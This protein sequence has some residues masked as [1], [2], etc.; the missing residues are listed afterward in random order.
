MIDIVNQY[1]G[2]E[3]YR[4]EQSLKANAIIES[5][6]KSLEGFRE[7]TNSFE[8]AN[9]RILG[10]LNAI[11]MGQGTVTLNAAQQQ[12]T[13]SDT[14]ARGNLLRQTLAALGGPASGADLSVDQIKTSLE[15]TGLI[16]DTAALK[17]VNSLAS[18]EKAMI[19]ETKK[20]DELINETEKLEAVNQTLTDVQKAQM[21]AEAQ[22]RYFI[23]GL[24][25]AEGET[26]PIRRGAILKDLMMPFTAW[27]KALA[28]GTLNM[29]EFASLVENF[30]SR[31]KPLL[32]SQGVSEEDIDGVR[33]GFFKKF[34]TVFPQ[35]FSDAVSMSFVSVRGPLEAA[36]GQ[37]AS[38]M[39]IAGKK[40]ED[41]DFSDLPG[42]LGPAFE[43]MGLDITATVGSIMDK[44][45]EAAAEK[46]RVLLKDAGEI[47]DSIDQVIEANLSFL[48]TG[49]VED[50]FD[51]AATAAENAA[52]LLT[53]F[54]MALVVHDFDGELRHLFRAFETAREQFEN[55]V[56]K[57][58]KVA[59]EE[60][61]GPIVYREDT[62]TKK[63]STPYKK[64]GDLKAALG[65][66]AAKGNRE[67]IVALAEKLGVATFEQGDPIYA[68]G[69]LGYSHQ[70]GGKAPIG[71]KEGPERSATDIYNDIFG[72][73]E[74]ISDYF[75]GWFDRQAG[76]A[77]EILAAAKKSKH[78]GNKNNENNN[79]QRA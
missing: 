72:E 5:T 41:I 74:G 25:R 52:A 45:E 56:E 37:I 28:G 65:A 42:L 64:L 69:G 29:R 1:V 18:N 13:L 26:D 79:S 68:S 32:R 78:R 63:E 34:S 51:D 24:A 47:A 73:G 27:S 58:E 66:D 57:S 23:S 7:R 31:I 71:Y 30:D 33:R 53:E 54:G 61:E 40:F 48:T 22:A 75:F 46:A 3:K 20:L 11:D 62:S 15:G 39:V 55:M 10:R 59:A 43:A 76:T 21:D 35:I 19:R 4:I 70:P 12:Q 2:V 60:T 9:E 49:G 44:A 36:L 17:I 77:A 14:R 6:N 8:K 16:F 50:A 67:A 38:S